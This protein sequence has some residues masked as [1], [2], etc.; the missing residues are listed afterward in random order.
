MP[1]AYEPEGRQFESVRAHHLN[2]ELA[3]SRPLK[4]RTMSANVGG[5]LGG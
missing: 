3:E 5:Q 1:L 2:Q 4:L